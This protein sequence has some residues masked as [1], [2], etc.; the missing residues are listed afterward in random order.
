METTAVTHS[1]IPQEAVELSRRLCFDMVFK[2]DVSLLSIAD[3]YE[4]LLA[5]RSKRPDPTEMWA[6]VF[7]F[8]SALLRRTSRE[9]SAADV[10]SDMPHL[11]K[12][13][14]WIKVHAAKASEDDEG[15]D[16]LFDRILQYGRMGEVYSILGRHLNQI[17][18]GECDAL[19]LLSQNDILQVYYDITNDQWKFFSSMKLYL[20]LLA[21][22]NSAMK[23]MEVGAGT[24]ST[25]KCV[26][27]ALSTFSS[28]GCSAR[29]SRFDF[30][31][32][33]Q[34]FLANAQDRF[35]SYPK[36]YFGVNDVEQ[37]LIPQGFEPVSYDVLVAANV[38][39]R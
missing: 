3:L 14:S 26:L 10:P 38:S 22:K 37:D 7:R 39:H 29:Y 25:T 33:S 2:A 8:V 6:A 15:M 17:L 21:H 30:T 12:Q 19:E 11:D 18:K 20:E 24:G 34:S 9:I 28:H 4:I 16:D 23:I 32:V 5:G 27:E 13:L 36:M 31:D 35:S 1:E